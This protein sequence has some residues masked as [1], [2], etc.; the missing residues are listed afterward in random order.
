M[1]LAIKILVCIL[2]FLAALGLFSILLNRRTVEMTSEMSQATLPIVSV[3]YADV[4]LNR[5]EGHKMRME[6]AYMR[7]SITPLSD[8]RI[9]TLSIDTYDANVEKIAYEVRSVDGDRLVEDSEVASFLEKHGNI[10]TTITLK[11]LLEDNTEYT[12]ITILT[13]E[14]GEELY[15]YT[16]IIKAYD[17]DAVSKI[18][19]AKQFSE[20]T[21]DKDGLND[22]IAMYLESDSTGD[23][24]NFAYVNIHSSFEM[25][26]WENLAVEK[27]SEVVV[28]LQELAPTTATVSLSYLV[29]LPDGREKE[30]YQVEEHYRMR[31]GT[32]RIYLLDYERTMDRY[33]FEQQNVFFGDKIMVGISDRDLSLTESED[34]N[35]VA[36]VK[37]GALF[38]CNIN[39]G[40]C[41]RVFSF[42][43][44]ENWDWRT[45]NS[46]HG[47]RIL[48]VSE[49]GDIAFCVFGYMNR[50]MHEG[51]CGILVYKYDGV[52]NTL[53]EAVFLPYA[54]SFEML[55]E[56]VEKLSYMNKEGE[57][58]LYLE[59]MIIKVN[60]ATCEYEVVVKD[61]TDQTFQVS[62]NHTM[63]VWME[64]ETPY[65]A[66]EMVLLDLSTGSSSV[67]KAG[68]GEYVKSLGFMGEDLLYGIAES[69]DI[70]TDSSGEVTFP[71]YVLQICNKFGILLKSYE[72]EGLYI[73]GHILDGNMITLE[74]MKKGGDGEFEEAA[75]DTI[76]NN[77]EQPVGKNTIELVT[78][79]HLRKIVQIVLR[80]ELPEKGLKYMVPKEIRYEGDRTLSIE[81]PKRNDRYF[82]YHK[83]EIAGIYTQP[84]QAVRQAYELAGSVINDF[85]EYV[86]IRGN[87]STKNQIMKITGVKEDET[88]SSMAV[89]LETILRYEGY[90]PD[91]QAQLYLGKNAMQILE[92]NLPE[93][94][95]LDLTGCSLESILY[96]VNQDIPVLAVS[97]D[98][99][100]VLIVGFNEQNTVW[101]N[102]ENG[103]VYKVGMND[104]RNYFEKNGN[105]FIT[106]MDEK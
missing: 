32:E 77:Q 35:Q 98:Q 74:R 106:Y 22:D 94:R 23:N 64:G 4:I 80:A 50:G 2:T 51:E 18:T 92:E 102:P 58:F 96:Y 86:W 65:N 95:I 54:K 29:S 10:T 57:L 9:L 53:E 97:E 103:K 56:N 67:I 25:V 76:M 5:M 73:T 88:K 93:H 75:P 47:I 1:K 36:F 21:F 7:E 63:L 99:S 20:K 104:S 69:A 82:V 59:G 8:G 34:G 71:M 44:E 39:N 61:I 17:Y 52:T 19:F 14:S 49:S 87:L 6:P 43:D 84:A 24:T 68:P 38:A 62:E 46:D 31:K 70:M 37:S 105:C 48:N 13:L 55:R 79:E 60:T 45:R 85:G 89:C 100:A 42:Y 30:Y 33:F 3:Q 26:T 11:D 72:Q 40:S 91:A 28:T 90:S 12:F 101:M 78:T 16:R 66:K 27:E 81:C 15:Y 83:G 41:A